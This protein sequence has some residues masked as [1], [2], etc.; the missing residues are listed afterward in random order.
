[1]SCTL[2]WCWLLCSGWGFLLWIFPGDH[3]RLLGSGLD[4]WTFSSVT[5]SPSPIGFGAS[6]PDRVRAYALH[7]QGAI[8]SRGLKSQLG[9]RHLG[10]WTLPSSCHRMTG[11]HRHFLR[12]KHPHTSGSDQEGLSFAVR[13][14]KGIGRISLP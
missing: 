5:A 9:G 14:K 12:S 8:T 7:E 2:F 3:P 13:C 11:I 6:V 1:M 4:L 10:L